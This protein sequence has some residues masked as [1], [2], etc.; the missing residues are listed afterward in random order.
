MKWIGEIK[1]DHGRINDRVFIVVMQITEEIALAVPV[2][3]IEYVIQT[4]GIFSRSPQV[5]ECVAH[6]Y[7]Q[8]LFAVET[9]S[10]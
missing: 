1:V 2:R 10:R 6:P 7:H 3:A 9:G 8:I 5:M 4:Q